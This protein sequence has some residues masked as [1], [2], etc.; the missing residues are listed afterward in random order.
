MKEKQ[1]NLRI[2]KQLKD[3]DERKN[4]EVAARAIQG[5]EIMKLKVIIKT[6]KTSSFDV[7]LQYSTLIKYKERIRRSFVLNLMTIPESP[8]VLRHYPISSVYSLLLYVL[9]LLTLFSHFI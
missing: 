1:G 6:I 3:F 2:L 8:V 7:V 4:Q 5:Q 9:H